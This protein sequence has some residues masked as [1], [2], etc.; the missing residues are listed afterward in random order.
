[1]ATPTDGSRMADVACLLSHVNA[2]LTI[3]IFLSLRHFV[4]SGIN[5]VGG[6]IE[7][8]TLDTNAGKQQPLA[9]TDV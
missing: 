9:A 7:E 5:K 4:V 2:F 6:T 3:T 1:M 8:H